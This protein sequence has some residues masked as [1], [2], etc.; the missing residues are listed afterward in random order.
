[1]MKTPVNVDVVLTAAALS[2]KAVTR[3]GVKVDQSALTKDI[4][5]G[6]GVGRVDVVRCRIHDV[7]CR[8]R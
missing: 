7:Q 3:V 8:H 2:W 1:M 4:G 6:N 5:D